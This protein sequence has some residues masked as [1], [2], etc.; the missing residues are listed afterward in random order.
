MSLA[1]AAAAEFVRASAVVAS[2][3]AA[4][5]EASE[6]AVGSEPVAAGASS[7]AAVDEM[8]RTTAVVPG[9]AAPVH[10]V[11]AHGPS[12]AEVEAGCQW[13]PFPASQSV[14]RAWVAAETAA[15]S[16]AHPCRPF[17]RG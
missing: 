5:Q 7:A 16:G 3:A 15:Q 6:E 13:D 2:S 4:V 11:L 9:S 17:H 10:L 14:L 1:G 12:F 8:T